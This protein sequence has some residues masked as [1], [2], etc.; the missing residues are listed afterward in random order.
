MFRDTEYFIAGEIQN[1]L[2]VWNS[3]LEDF[4][5]RDEILKYISG[6]VSVFH[7]FEHFEGEYNGKYYDSDLPPETIFPNNKISE[8][9]DDFISSSLLEKVRN[10]SISVWGKEGQ[11]KPPH[12]LM[13]LTIEPSKP[14]L[15]HDDRFLNLWMRT[16]KVSF[17][18]IT[19][20]PCYIDPGHFQSKLDD[21]S[22]YDHI[23]LS[24]DSGEFF[25]LFWKGWFF[26]HN[27]IPFG[28][29]PSA[30]VY[31]TTGLGLTHFIR[32]KGVPL[33]QYIDDRHVGQLRLAITNPT[34]SDLDLEKAGIFIAALV[35]VSCGD[36]IG[37]K[38]SV[39]IPVQAITFLGFIS[40]SV[41]QAFLLPKEKKQKFADLR[42]SII[43]SK[44]VAVKTLQRFAGKAVS[45]ALAVPAA[46]LFTREVNFH[47]GKGL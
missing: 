22:G 4:A 23:L 29:S 15:C 13:P 24:E 43:Q 3:I 35:L 12:L 1:H 37:L 38:K 45:F 8:Q 47:I 31:H 33:S 20:L 40:D 2:D 41:K 18:N 39:F 42:D 21:K 34:W 44:T 10:G 25:G 6:R 5:K 26:I 7:F 17:D 46:K 36:F 28:W 16:P 32:S 14:R 9:F 19:D 11:C 30:Y 27:T